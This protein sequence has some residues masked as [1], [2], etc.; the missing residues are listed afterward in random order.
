MSKS[1]ASFA[2]FGRPSG[3]G[4]ELKGWLSNEGMRES[5]ARILVIGGPNGGMPAVDR[6]GLR[7]ERLAGRFA[8]ITSTKARA[9]L[10]D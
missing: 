3:E 9:E 5:D 10:F 4:K 8:F 2:S 7:S 1:W 6:R